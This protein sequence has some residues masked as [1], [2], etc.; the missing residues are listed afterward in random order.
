MPRENVGR[1]IACCAEIGRP[2][3]GEVFDHSDR[4]LLIGQAEGDRSLDGVRTAAP[5]FV[6]DLVRIGHGEGVVADAAIEMVGGRRRAGAAACYLDDQVMIGDIERQRRH[7]AEA[8]DRRRPGHRVEDLHK[9]ERGPEIDFDGCCRGLN[10]CVRGLV[11]D[12]WLVPEDDLVAPIRFS[13][14]RLR[15]DDGMPSIE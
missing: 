9:A 14:S 8:F 4:M 3:Q 12:I 10:G 7:V 11:P 2:G 5:A 13:V 15:A 6:D 1:I